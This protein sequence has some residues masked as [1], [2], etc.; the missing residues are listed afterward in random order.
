MNR[1][2]LIFYEASLGNGN[3]I[4]GNFSQQTEVFPSKKQIENYLQE[5]N[6]DSK[7]VGSV[8]TNIIELSQEDY[9]NW[10]K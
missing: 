8:V 7:L 4:T 3:I 1:Y 10:V 9:K 6:R 2:F 5:Y